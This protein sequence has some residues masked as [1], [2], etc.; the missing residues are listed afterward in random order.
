MINNYHKKFNEEED[1]KRQYEPDTSDKFSMFRKKNRKTN[2]P[3][4]RGVNT[5]NTQSMS[6]L[7]KRNYHE[8]PKK[9]VTTDDLADN[10]GDGSLW[11]GQGQN[12]FLFS[13]NS[14]KKLGDIVVMK[15]M[16]KLKNEITT[17][18]N[19]AYPP[20]RIKKKKDPNPGQEVD[21]DGKDKNGDKE[22]EEGP[23][24]KVFDL[25]S[26]VVVEEINKD[27][28]LVR[29]RKD[30]L[31]QNRKR[32]VEVEAMISRRDVADDDGVMSTNFLESTVS[33][34]R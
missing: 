12:N 30:V 7:I 27:H 32:K 24:D 2:F 21:K 29:G 14:Q 9:R 15:V 22:G 28:L 26:G 5:Q 34:I 11:V 3:E 17:E 18:L 25:I 4:D 20:P 23:S 31:F 16:A 19:R 8:S 10:G 33:V 6:P 13:K 1:R